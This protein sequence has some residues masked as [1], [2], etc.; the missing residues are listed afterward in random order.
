MF[1]PDQKALKEETIICYIDY[2]GWR[3]NPLYSVLY[4]L[5]VSVL[6][7]FT[8]CWLMGHLSYPNVF[9]NSVPFIFA[10]GILFGLVALVL[11]TLKNEYIWA[12][13]TDVFRGSYSM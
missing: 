6:A 12:A 2:K 9:F 1:F 8:N 13:S 3:F 7:L 10:G 11:F 4:L 5:L